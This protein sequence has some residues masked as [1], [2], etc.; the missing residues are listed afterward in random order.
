MSEFPVGKTD[1]TIVY[2]DLKMANRHGLVSGATGTGKTV[3][4]QTL[5]ENFSEAGVSV[6]TADVKGDLSGLSCAAVPSAKLQERITALKMKDFIP[7]KDPVVFWDLYGKNGHP[8]RTTISEM[9]PLLLGRLLGLNDTQQGILNATF[10]YA[11]DEGLLLLDLKDLRALLDLMSKNASSLKTKYGNLSS[12]SIGAIQRGLLTLNEAGGDQFF[13]EPALNI[14]D[15]LL[16]DANGKG[17]IN[18]LDA[19]KLMTDPRLYST[20]LLWLLSELFE[21]LPEVGDLDKPKLVFFFDE[22]HLFFDSA[23]KVLIEKIEQLIRLIR[24]KGV[25]VYFISQNTIDIPETVLGQLGNRIQHALRAFTP[26]DQKAI[27]VTASTLRKNPAFDTETL[28]TELKIGEALISF[29]D[30]NGAPN[31][32]EKLSVY[33]PHSRIGPISAEERQVIMR[34]SPVAGRYDNAL[35]R[36]S[37]YE[38]INKKFTKRKEPEILDESKYSNPAPPKVTKEPR[39]RETATEAMLKS[40]ARSIGSNVGRQI[41]RGLMGSIFGNR[42]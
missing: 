18:I 12:S 36:E 8:I 3:T 17:I 6:F 31:M 4:L 40:A 29:L 11:D 20:F 23:P 9:G 19:T 27:K 15:L 16:K 13:G 33:P 7:A 10:S 1:S 26:K 41:V 37:A 34:Q 14:E 42:R 39:Q 21:K 2:F 30:E 28:I 22:A 5:A 25:G 35:D 24:S 38:Q 32:V